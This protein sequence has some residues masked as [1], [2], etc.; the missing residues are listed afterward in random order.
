MEFS[1]WKLQIRENSIGDHL[2]TLLRSI[3]AAFFCTHPGSGVLFALALFIFSPR[4][5]IFGVIGTLSAQILASVLKLDRAMMKIG[6]FCFN[7]TLVGLYWSVL[8]PLNT[9]SIIA[10]IVASA[11]TVPLMILLNRMFCLSRMNLPPLSTA[12]LVVIY[13]AIILLRKSGISFPPTLIAPPGFEAIFTGDYLFGGDWRSIADAF[14]LRLFGG[15]FFILTGIAVHSRRSLVNGLRGLI[16]GLAAA[17]ILGGNMGL[18]WSSLYLVN[19][20]PIFI[21][22]DGFFL[23]SNTTSRA[24]IWACGIFGVV[25]W[26]VCIPLFEMIALPEYTVPFLLTT[27][28][29][30]ILSH[31]RFVQRSLPHLRPVP[32]VYVHSPESSDRWFSE[33]KTA[34]RFWRIIQPGSC[35][36]NWKGDMK[37]RTDRAVDIILNS[38]S[39][40]AFTGAG[41]ST[42]SHIPD[43]RTGQIHWK[44]YDTSHFRF[45]QFTLSEKSRARY[46]E[47]SQD[48]YLLIKQAKPNRAHTAFKELE[49]MGKLAGIITQNVDRL[50]Q[51]AGVS[52]E[53]VLELH[54]NE[55]LVSCLNC[56]RQY[57]REEI[58]DWILNGVKVPYCLECQGILKPDSI[59]FGQPMPLDV[60]R[61]ALDMVMRCDVMIVMGTS[62]LVQP[63][64]LLP[65]KAK[66]NGAKLMIINLTSTVY[67]EHADVLIRD[68]A[69]SAMGRIMSRI[70]ETRPYIQVT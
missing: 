7:G 19:I 18:S 3:G 54:G 64:A 32:L 44:K 31:L 48:F 22:L 33:L 36:E 6:F 41:V 34:E 51:K 35:G 47:M 9:T 63:A 30:L 46:W 24:Y 42:E 12:S 53:K 61:R 14:N 21:A 56:G 55:L 67:D 66:E 27:L 2:D 28:L 16:F 1:Y 65:W 20:I 40:V 37:N 45:E 57:T 5:C 17:Y 29:A 11:L 38:K 50:H 68:M 15:I 10:L 43:Y 60:S 52:A 4:L 59:A 69:G 70:D 8:R 49:N 62:L 23:V 25:L 13:P 26:A 58:Y 39:I